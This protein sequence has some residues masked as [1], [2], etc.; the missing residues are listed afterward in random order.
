MAVGDTSIIDPDGLH[1]V[2]DRSALECRTARNH[3]DVKSA[4]TLGG[5]TATYSVAFGDGIERVA[6]TNPDDTVCFAK[7]A[8]SFTAE[9]RVARPGH[10]VHTTKIEVTQSR[11][12][13]ILRRD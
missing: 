4:N 11:V 13:S 1:R 2:E 3:V 6:E 5:D 7:V 12:T 10:A 8:G 9:I